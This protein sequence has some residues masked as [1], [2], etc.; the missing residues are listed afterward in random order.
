MTSYTEFFEKAQAEFLNS[1]KQA[2]QL[3]LNT[4]AAVSDLV[5]A[6]PSVDAKELNATQFPSPTQLVAQSFEFTN[7]LLETRKEY[8]I[9]LAELATEAQ[10]QFSD[11]AKR[12]AEAAKN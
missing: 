9:K 12:F 6:V 11:T 8:A 7:Q 3:N 5:S 2:Q 1:L 4:L 10:K